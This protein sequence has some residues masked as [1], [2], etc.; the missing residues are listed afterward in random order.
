MNIIVV[1]CGKIGQS[2][3]SSLISEGHDVVAIDKDQEIIEEVT[4][5]YDV[6]GVCGIGT[7]CEI[8]TEAGANKADIFIAVTGSDE[9]NMLSCYLAK[10]LG[11]ENTIARIRNREYNEKSL[12]FLQH[13]LGLSMS[14]NP[15]F[16]AAHD[17]Y[18]VLKLPSA[19]HIETFSTRNFEI[20][21]LVL[22]SDSPLSGMKIIDLRRQ[23]KA[24]F[25]ICAVCREGK[26]YIPDGNFELKSG[27]KIALTAAPS[28]IIKLLKSLKITQRSAKKVMILGASRTGYYLARMLLLSG[29]SVV[30]IDK[31]PK[32]CQEICEALPNATV[33]LG[34][35]AQQEL[36][37]EE[38]INN[39]DAFISLTGMD[40]QNILISYYAQ[41]ENVPK[42]ITK[43]NRN[44]FVP[45]ATGLGLDTII[46]P[47]RTITD[48]ILRYVRALKNSVGSNVEKLYK[49]M[50]GNAE[51][52]KFNVR[53]DFKYINTP[54]KDISFKSN[55]LIA[56]ILRNRKAMVPTGDSVILPGDKVI[57][58][59]TEHR[60]YDLADIIK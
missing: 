18:N 60:L 6:I 47:R 20:I 24:K 48:V 28:E 32:R 33:I 22:R 15:E 7:D 52:L 50:D 30:I 37:R 36:L 55:I 43:V 51:A 3:I 59:S 23:H 31:D 39:V 11:A 57:V 44:E 2:I 58:I 38:G 12:G 53:E 42:V 27:D 29:C 16:F 26:V 34:D 13:E 21:E 1:G 8:L 40:E 4:N 19:A 17:I 56:G 35:G 25:L 5:I 10:T 9:L 14:I 49:I 41:S 46:S 45:L 54:L